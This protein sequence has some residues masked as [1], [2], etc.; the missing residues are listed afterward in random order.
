[1]LWLNRISSFFSRYKGLPTMIAV[2]LIVL[3][4]ILQFFNLG[5]LSTSN[6]FLH[7]GIIVGLVGILL[8]E[9]LG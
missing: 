2:A 6:L 4:F 5:W 8:A 7:L 9:A 1:M 3:N